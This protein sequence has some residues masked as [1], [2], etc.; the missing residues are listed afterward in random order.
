MEVSGQLHAPAALSPGE[1]L[2]VPTGWEVGWIPTGLE[3]VKQKQ[4]F[5]A[6]VGNRTPDV[7]AIARC[8]TNSHYYYY[9]IS[10]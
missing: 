4:K 5:L 8:Y 6:P 7:Q 2:L 9:F 10:Y 3:S 1:N